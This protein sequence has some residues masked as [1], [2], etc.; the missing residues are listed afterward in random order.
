MKKSKLDFSLFGFRVDYDEKNRVVKQ[1][2][3]VFENE[4]YTVS[5]VD[6]G[7]DYGSGRGL[8]LYWETMMFR[9]NDVLDLYCERYSSRELALQGHIQLVSDIADGK[10]VLTDWGFIPKEE[11]K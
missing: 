4:R 6:L 10:Y 7:I 9:E 2:S 8:P 1:E 5:T 3:I 11:L